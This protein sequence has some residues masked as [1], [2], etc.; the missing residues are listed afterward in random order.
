LPVNPNWLR[1]WKKRYLTNKKIKNDAE[2]LKVS[3]GR[4]KS[5]GNKIIDKLPTFQY[6]GI[7]KLE[8]KTFL[9]LEKFYKKMNNKKISLTHF[10]NETIKVKIASYKYSV[11]KN[12]WFEIDNITDLEYLKKNVK[13]ILP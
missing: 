7:L 5:I 8:Y 1:S 2:D 3:N 10:I 9:K 11:F 12:Y 4:V 6:M 13:S